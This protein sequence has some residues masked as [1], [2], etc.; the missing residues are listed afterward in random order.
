M[1]YKQSDFICTCILKSEGEEHLQTRSV[2]V[3]GF[4]IFGE[5]PENLR[6][7]EFSSDSQNEVGVEPKAE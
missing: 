6:G 5:Y 2:P 3:Q 7:L 4:H 1:S